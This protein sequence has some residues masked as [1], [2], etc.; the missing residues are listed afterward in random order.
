MAYGTISLETLR[1][2][3]PCEESWD[4]MTG[5]DRV[6]FCSRCGQNVYNISQFS[7]E[8]AEEFIQ[9]SEGRPCMRLY[10]R[11]DGTV[12]TKDCPVGLRAMRRWLASFLALAAAMTMLGFGWILSSSGDS[13]RSR[14]SRSPLRDFE[15]FRTI[16]EWFDPTTTCTMGVPAPPPPGN[17]GQN[18]SQGNP[19]E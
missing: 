5:T 6:R 4:A 2:A 7:R 18:G 3:S 8:E 16:M 12:L 14:I 19:G 13:H 11:K 15:P 9:Q 10:R 1:V 17:S